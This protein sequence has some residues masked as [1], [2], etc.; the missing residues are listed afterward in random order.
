[1]HVMDSHITRISPA[2]SIARHRVVHSHER[3]CDHGWYCAA[4]VAVMH[5]WWCVWLWVHGCRCVGRGWHEML[6]GKDW[7]ARSSGMY[8]SCGELRLAEAMRVWHRVVLLSEAIHVWCAQCVHGHI[9]P[10]HGHDESCEG[11]CLGMN[12]RWGEVV[13]ATCEVAQDVVMIAELEHE[14]G[15]SREAAQ[16]LHALDCELEHDAVPKIDVRVLRLDLDLDLGL[17][18]FPAHLT[19]E[20]DALLG[21]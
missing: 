14:S 4:L 11:G 16:L 10:G 7:A 1:M 9:G 18:W 15:G 6:Y 3:V 5:A 8:V 19:G 12:V 20:V 17:D 13:C 2:R 21:S